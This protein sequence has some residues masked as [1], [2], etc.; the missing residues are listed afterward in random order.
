MS[1]KREMHN[2][3]CEANLE[4]CIRQYVESSLEN[5]MTKLEIPNDCEA[6]VKLE[7]H[8]A[9]CDARVK[10]RQGFLSLGRPRPPH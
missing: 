1:M 3:M 6:G 5:T 9:M 7:M 8:N 2:V 4:D 10:S